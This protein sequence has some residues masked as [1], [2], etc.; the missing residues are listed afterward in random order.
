MTVSIGAATASDPSDT[1]AD[2]I[3]TVDVPLMR[4]LF[5]TIDRWRR[6]FAD[7]WPEENGIVCHAQTT[8]AR[9]D[10]VLLGFSPRIRCQSLTPILKSADPDRARTKNRISGRT[11]TGPSD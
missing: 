9:D 3:W 10:D 11:L 6:V 4:F 1:V 2:L 7:E 8:L 5:G